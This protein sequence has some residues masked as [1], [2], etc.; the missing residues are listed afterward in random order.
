MK[1]PKAV[2]EEHEMEDFMRQLEEATADGTARALLVSDKAAAK[3]FVN[4]FE[5][6]G[7]DLPVRYKPGMPPNGMLLVRDKIS[8]P[9]TDRF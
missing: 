3:D 2:L 5:K 9:K 7:I 8:F 4:L 1:R 6:L